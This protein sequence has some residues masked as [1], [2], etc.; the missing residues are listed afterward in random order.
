[1]LLCGPMRRPLLKGCTVK[2][3]VTQ[4]ESVSRSAEY[5]EAAKVQLTAGAHPQ[6][7]SE[8]LK[9]QLPQ[10]SWGSA[11]VT[12]YYPRSAKLSDVLLW[13]AA[14]KSAHWSQK[15]GNVKVSFENG[16]ATFKVAPN[17]SEEHLTQLVD[18]LNATTE[19]LKASQST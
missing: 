5:L 16:G 4:A 19:V 2:S 13:S 15:D 9:E 1:M 18:S 10:V 3:P 14:A 12:T 7:A 11:G 8:E 17:T 6:V